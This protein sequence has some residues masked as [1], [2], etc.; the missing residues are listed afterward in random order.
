MWTPVRCPGPN[1][2]TACGSGHEPRAEASVFVRIEGADGKFKEYQYALTREPI[3]W[4]IT[5]VTEPQARG[6]RV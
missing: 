6:S 1:D 4:R 5:G 2:F 3:G